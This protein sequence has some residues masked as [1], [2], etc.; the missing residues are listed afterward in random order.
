MGGSVVLKPQHTPLGKF[1]GILIGALAWN[2]FIGTFAYFLFFVEDRENVPL[3][4]KIIIGVLLFAGVFLLISAFTSF[5]ALFNPR[6]QLTAQTTTV[7]LGGE[8]RFSWKV[9]GR[10]GM[11]RKLR[12]VFEGREEATYRR[13]TTTSTDSKVF[14][15]I[16]VFETTEREF[17]S[18]GTARVAVPPNVMHTFE[19]GNNKVLWRLKVHGEIPRWP[20]VADEYPI[21]VLP[22]PAS[23]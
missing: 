17:L 3:F 20:D 9:T 2:G 6:V 23:A 12:V 5:L 21:T 18:Q 1:V 8:L 19:A 7:S 14:A 22:Q 4:P 15:E 10:A 16:P 11:L 13:G